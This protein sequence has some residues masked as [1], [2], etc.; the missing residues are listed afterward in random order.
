MKKVVEGLAKDM[1][2]L[3]QLQ[4]SR[5]SLDGVPLNVP[6]HNAAEFRELCSVISNSEDARQRLV[7]QLY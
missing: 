7:S 6:C 1:K 2:E 3:L 5:A 4:K